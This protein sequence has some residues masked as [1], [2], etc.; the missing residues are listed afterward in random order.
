MPEQPSSLPSTLRVRPSWY[1]ISAIVLF[2]CLCQ[3]GQSQGIPE[4][5]HVNLY[6]PHLA[7]G[8]DSSSHWEVTITASNSSRSEADL[9]LG[10]YND[11]GVSFPI[12]FPQGLRSRMTVN[13][14]PSHTTSFTSIPSQHKRI[15]GWAYG[16]SDVPVL[17]HIVLRQLRNGLPIQAVTISPTVP[18]LSHTFQV[19]PK[20]TLVI[21]NVATETAIDVPVALF[22]AKG[23]LVGSHLIQITSKGH[24]SE[25]IHSLFPAVKTS[26]LEFMG[27]ISIG[28]SAV[29]GS[30]CP[31]CNPR[32]IDL[33]THI[34]WAYESDDREILTGLPKG[35]VS[36]PKSH[37]DEI[38][39]AFHQ[40][41]RSSNNFTQEIP[42]NLKLTI[43]TDQEVNA[44]ARNGNEIGI[45]LGLAE[46]LGD[47]PSELAFVIGHELGHI[48]QQRTQSN[49]FDENREHD[50]DFWGVLLSL[51]AGY[52][53]YGAAGAL[54]KLAMATGR[55][56]L[57]N[58]FFEDVPIANAHQSFNTRLSKLFDK[59]SFACTSSVDMAQFCSA[60]KTI[61]HPHLPDVSPLTIKDRIE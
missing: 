57:T 46:L 37:H 10:F 11:E 8:G 18:A 19:G 44:F 38:W 15:T 25:T 32:G 28:P 23:D 3:Q 49:A 50:A 9:T 1:F 17:V 21:A 51:G 14:M 53:P 52:D 33:R 16:Y 39:L 26:E 47:S 43:S 13:L 6:F 7:Y 42:S 48:Y 58:Q 41:L 40:T 5:A 36:F 55:A 31:S 2:L 30:L 34:A 20:A 29:I 27:L 54:A 59:I 61:V 4:S 12:H 24:H 60:Y 22:D 56:S 35:A 45:T